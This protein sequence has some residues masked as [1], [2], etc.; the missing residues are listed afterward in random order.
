M[1]VDDGKLLLDSF[2]ELDENSTLNKAYMLKSKKM[3]MKKLN[4]NDSL[5]F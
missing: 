3:I 4:V 2:F 1:T 5:I